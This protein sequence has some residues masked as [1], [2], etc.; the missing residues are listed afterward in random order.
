MA[1]DFCV[2]VL[3]KNNE[4]NDEEASSLLEHKLFYRPQSNAVLENY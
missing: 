3:E 1:K 2:S 4:N